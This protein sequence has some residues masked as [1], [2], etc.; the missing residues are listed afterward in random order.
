M[1][2]F[3][4]LLL[5]CVVLMQ[6]ASRPLWLNDRVYPLVPITPDFPLAPA[7]WDAVVWGFALASL[8]LSYW[9]Y[10]PAIICFL[11]VT[12][13]LVLADQTRLQPW[14]YL[15]WLLLLLSLA[16]ERSAFT[17]CRL[18]LSAVYVWSG[19][20]KLNPDYFNLVVPWFVRPAAGLL[21]EWMLAVL[22]WG[23]GAA[24]GIEVFVGVGL[25]FAGTRPAAL[26][27]VVLVHLCALTLLGPWGHAHNWIVWPWNVFMPALAL[28]LF[29]WE[30]RAELWGGLRER[31]WA[32][33][34]VVVVSVLPVL[35]YFGL[36]DS[37]LSF[38]LYAGN[39]TRADL[40]I[41][42]G[43]KAK[44]PAPVLPFVVATPE[45]YNRELQGPF[46]VLVE[47]WADKIVRVPP[48][49][50]S[51]NYR[52][53]AAYLSTFASDPDEVRLVLIP[54]VGPSRFYRGSDLRPEAGIPLPK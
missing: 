24:P 43:V 10:R 38:S 49:P 12:T 44:L 18:L 30:A 7:P 45:P 51:R 8:G 35:S 11:V 36:W 40:F 3:R 31:L 1:A 14:V 29:P 5:I 26:I 32:T 39:L 53:I 37:Y 28:V 27:A 16:P 34:V 52:R 41:T 54:R 48:L 17:T 13:Y 47:L 21:P 50:E 25:W 22:R 4:G 42:E 33:A 46:V 15:F 23:V 6:I 2:W 9:R 20:Q 19:L